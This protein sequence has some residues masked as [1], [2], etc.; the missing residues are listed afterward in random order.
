M[1][2]DCLDI[3]DCIAL[4]DG[5][6][7]PRWDLVKA[8]V[9]AVGLEARDAAWTDVTR[10][11]LEALRPAL[12]PKYRIGESDNF[13]VLAWLSEEGCAT[14]LRI[15]ERCRRTLL[16]ELAGLASFD[17]PGKLAVL[18]FRRSA[19]YYTYLAAHY[20]EGRY[21]GS[22]GV[23]VR[24]GR[25]HIVMVGSRLLNLENTL[26][27]E[28]TH[29]ALTHLRLPLWVEE[30]LTQKF[31]Q[32]LANGRPL[33]VTGE[34]ARRHKRYWGKHGLRAFWTGASFHKPG[35][36]QRLSYDLAQILRMLLEVEHQPRWFGL[37]KSPSIRLAAF[38]KTAG[39]ADCGEAAAR[40][41]L[42]FGLGDL[43]ARFLGPGEW[44][45]PAVEVPATATPSAHP[46]IE[47]VNLLRQSPGK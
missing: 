43:A 37:D 21:G 2:P 24:K 25:A 47:M 9:E 17:A 33:V 16:A 22:A 11:W 28:L 34:M 41:H 42:G 46:A 23:Q 30:G 45:P 5:V 27:H 44:S 31:K 36:V 7:R 1:T 6:P 10:Q 35:K 26:A 18:A 4:E 39:R 13:L 15:A 40:T 32:I 8:R 19:R 14:L 12:V 20:S 3:S 38:L 29:A